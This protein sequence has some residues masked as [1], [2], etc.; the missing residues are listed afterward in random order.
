MSQHFA[1]YTSPSWL[2]Q[3]KIFENTGG[4]ASQTPGVYDKA[5]LFEIKV[6]KSVCNVD[7]NGSICA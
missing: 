2:P 5:V 1:E 3:P 6:C 7:D 4:K